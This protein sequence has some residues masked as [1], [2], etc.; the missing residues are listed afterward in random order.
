MI[1]STQNSRVKAVL[2]L[3]EKARERKKQGLFI[4]EGPR[5]F[6][7]LSPEDCREIYVSAEY[8][9]Q[10]GKEAEELLRGRP[11]E[12]VSEDV[13]RSMSDTRNPQGIL[14]VARQKS[15]TLEDVLG[16]GTARP[17][18]L[19]ILETLQD[20]GNLGTILRAG[21]G[22]GVTG[23]IMNEESADVYNPKVIRSTMGSIFRVPFFVTPDLR[24][25]IRDIRKRGVRIFAAH[26]HG[27]A[28]YEDMDYR[29]PSGFLI[30]NEAAGLTEETASLA[31]A[32]VIIPMAGRVESLNAAIAASVLLFEAARQRRNRKDS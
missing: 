3:R 28:N 8:L 18:L 10:H 17:P 16:E 13:L 12:E 5:M 23:V 26:L 24:G 7:E 27:T 30:G 21:E 31:D 2:A 19:I 1:T 29:E 32:R 22:A 25:T 9:R 14:A 20:P 11:Y 4:V 6:A 15:W